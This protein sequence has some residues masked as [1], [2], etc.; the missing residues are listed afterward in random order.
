MSPA[1]SVA[2]QLRLGALLTVAVQGQCGWH[3][4]GQSR[5]GNEGDAGHFRRWVV[6][7]RSAGSG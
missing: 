7:K 3:H 2:L 4:Q 5:E 1:L 6:G